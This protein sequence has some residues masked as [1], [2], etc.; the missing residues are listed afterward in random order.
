[1]ALAYGPHLIT[2]TGTGQPSGLVT[3]ATT[4]VTG[5]AGT[6]TSFGV[7]GTAGQGTDLL[8]DLFGSLAEPYTRSPS[9][10][11]LMR[12]AT[13]SSIRKLKTTAGDLV[14]TNFAGPP[15]VDGSQANMLG[16]A[17]SWTRTWPRWPT[18]RSPRCWRT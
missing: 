11:W 13:L 18:P 3:T 1:L 8:V 2:G 17:L 6:G 10:A 4:G 15:Q 9:L 14:G 5:P 16:A 12:T 7:Q